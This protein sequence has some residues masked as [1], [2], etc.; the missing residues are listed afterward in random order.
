MNS[1]PAEPQGKPSLFQGHSSHTHI[2]TRIIFLISVC[3]HDISVIKITNDSVGPSEW[4]TSYRRPFLICPVHLCSLL[5]YQMPTLTLYSSYSNLFAVPRMCLAY[6]CPWTF[7]SASGFPGGVSDKELAC[8]RRRCKRRWFDPWVGR[9]PWKR[10][11][12][13]T[14]V[15]LPGDSCGQRS[16]ADVVRGV[17]KSWTRLERLSMHAQAFTWG[18]LCLRCLS[19]TPALPSLASSHLEFKQCSVSPSSRIP[20]LF[21]TCYHHKLLCR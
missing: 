12:Q 14:P 16:L 20:H 13:H 3:S 5:S 19:P 6:S 1:L 21:S 7:T 8:Q 10:A 15:F 9:I 11:W 17:T 18:L 2:T 4:K